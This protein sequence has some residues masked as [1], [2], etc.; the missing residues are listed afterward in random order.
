MEIAAAWQKYSRE[1]LS[2]RIYNCQL[3]ITH[4]FKVTFIFGIKWTL[5]EYT[6]GPVANKV[7]VDGGESPLNPYFYVLKYLSDA[8]PAPEIYGYLVR[9]HLTSKMNRT[10]F[11]TN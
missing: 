7:R 5:T 3:E 10:F 2:T 6:D 9:G 11:I 1:Y 8:L 4:Y